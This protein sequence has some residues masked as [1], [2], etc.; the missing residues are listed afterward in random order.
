[1]EKRDIK[2]I[3]TEVE[4]LGPVRKRLTVEVPKE[5]VSREMDAAYRDLRSQVALSGFRKGRVPLHILKARFGEQVLSD[6]ATRLI[7]RTYPEALRLEKL[8]PLSNPEIEIKSMGENQNFSYSAVVDIRPQV[9][10]EGYIGMELEKEDIEVTDAEVDDAL[11]RLR[12]SRAEFREVN[13]P[14]AEG[15]MVTIDFTA[16]SG[17]EPLKN[18]SSTDYPVIIGSEGL[19]PGIS[20]G[21]KGAAK[22]DNRKIKTSFPG[23]YN[24]ESLAGKEVVFDVTVKSVKEKVVPE[25]DDEL[26][27]DFECESLDALKEKVR[28]EIRKG[29]E[30]AE[31]ERLKGEILKNLVERND[32]EVPDSVVDRYLSNLLRRMLDNMKRGIVAPED[33][34]LSSEEL[35][36]RYREIALRQAKGDIILDEIAEKEKIE[37]S[38]EEVERYLKDMA[39]RAGQPFEALKARIEKQGALEA[40]ARE[41]RNEKVLDLILGKSRDKSRIILP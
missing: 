30:E 21:L 28:E 13:R 22:G 7:E 10:V 2:D 39:A 6:V 38:D 9:D 17:G 19:L 12:Q 35:K 41:V 34:D 31:K 3:K 23:D 25:L 1:M 4:S 20:E 26:A 32:F 15:D 14:A 8:T 5:E 24:D 27:K 40:V 33:R 29:K 18:G 16:S 37:V 11:E 36:K